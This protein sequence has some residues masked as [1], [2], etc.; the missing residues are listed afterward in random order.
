M[1]LS[2]HKDNVLKKKRKQTILYSLLGQLLNL[3]TK[4]RVILSSVTIGSHCHIIALGKL[5]LLL[6][7]L[8]SY[9]QAEVTSCSASHW[10]TSQALIFIKNLP[11]KTNCLSMQLF[12]FWFSFCNIKNFHWKFSDNVHLEQTMLDCKKRT[13]KNTQY[14]QIFLAKS[15]LTLMFGEKTHHIHKIVCCTSSTETCITIN[16]SQCI[17]DIISL[18]RGEG[19]S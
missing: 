1:A 16:H 15:T 5:Q 9:T 18:Q 12:M 6:G 10:Q 4:N 7:K 11:T 14:T 17:H 19:A 2:I 3:I 13:Q 8:A